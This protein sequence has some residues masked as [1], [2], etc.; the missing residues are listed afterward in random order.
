MQQFE[1]SL[2]K[3]KEIIE[4]NFK[5]NKSSQNQIMKLRVLE[6]LYNKI[7]KDIFRLKGIASENPTS[8]LG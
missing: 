5:N 1:L 2:K 7:E 4:K 6:D 8:I 3:H